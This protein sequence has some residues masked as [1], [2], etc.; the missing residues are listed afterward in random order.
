[1]SLQPLASSGGA[2]G[3]QPPTVK[4]PEAGVPE[5]MTLEGNWVR[6]AY[7]NE[8]YAIIG[9]QVAQ[10]SIGQEWMLLEFGTTV[11]DGVPDYT[12]TRDALSL[13]TPDNKTV[14]LASKAEYQAA[15][16]VRA[17]E[18]REKVQRDSINY[19]PPSASRA[20][21]VGF[22]AELGSRAMA[23]D[24]VELSHTRGCVGR[25]YFHVPGGITYGQYWL[26]VKFQKSL[27]RVPFRILT[28]EEEK[29]LSRNFGDIR[30]QVQEAFK[31][32]KKTN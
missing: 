2:Q 32:K 13:T 4:I 30:K 8:G 14:A 6:V 25:L 20:C 17:L 1:V 22:F 23:Y 15:A 24:Q 9:Y 3:N 21:R 31:P 11:R 27:V 10:R 29:T 26:N 19:F 7:N 12:L 16:E 28:K 5:I 18:A